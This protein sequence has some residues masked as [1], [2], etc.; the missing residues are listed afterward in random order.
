MIWVEL[1]RKNLQDR[2]KN[3]LILNLFIVMYDI[4][5]LHRKCEY[6]IYKWHEALFYQHSGFLRIRYCDIYCAIVIYI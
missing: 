1:K 5:I 2:K 3:L 4:I 6:C